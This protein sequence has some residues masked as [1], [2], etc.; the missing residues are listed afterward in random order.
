MYEK[1]MLCTIVFFLGAGALAWLFC[2]RLNCVVDA[3]L[4]HLRQQ[5]QMIEDKVAADVATRFNG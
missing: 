5:Q 1:F 2:H 3:F 4:G